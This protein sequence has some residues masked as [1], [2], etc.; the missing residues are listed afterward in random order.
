M[1]IR[2]IVVP[3]YTTKQVATLLDLH[4]VTVKHLIG[5]GR[6][7][8]VLI[9][10]R[11]L[12]PRDSL[13]AHLMEQIRS[14]KAWEQAATVLSDHSTDDEA[15]DAVLADAHSLVDLFTRLAAEHAR[16]QGDDETVE[17]LM[18]LVPNTARE[19]AR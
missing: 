16:Y 6:L 4:L 2:R 15:F 14:S 3:S 7:G 9:D 1:K 12:V 19:Q 11:R 13:L 5:S 18:A 17:R 10:G 8:S